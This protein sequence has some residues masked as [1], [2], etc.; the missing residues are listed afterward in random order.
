M[1]Q[2]SKKKHMRLLSISDSEIMVAN[3]D[4]VRWRLVG[5]ACV[6]LIFRMEEEGQTE[7]N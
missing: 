6:E 3:A 1:I 2:L 7:T 5:R 4:R